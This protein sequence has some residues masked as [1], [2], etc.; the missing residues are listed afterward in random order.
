MSP[1]VAQVSS[2]VLAPFMV[3]Y[4]LWVTAQARLRGIKRLYYV[5]RDAEVMLR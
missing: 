1:A 4:A 3:G 5:A 2:G